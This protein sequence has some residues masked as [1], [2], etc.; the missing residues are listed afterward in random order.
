MIK[1]TQLEI[2]HEE[3][4]HKRENNNNNYVA[5]CRRQQPAAGQRRYP[6]PR[7]WTVLPPARA[8]PLGSCH[9]I[10]SYRSRKKR[11]KARHAWHLVA[12]PAW[13][14]LSQSSAIPIESQMLMSSRTLNH[15]HSRPATRAWR[16]PHF[17]KSF[18]LAKRHQPL[19]FR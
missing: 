9:A 11:L 6:V 8:S 4:H 3:A 19:R 15:L 14:A 16:R 13:S 2:L 1:D 18:P 12:E 17:I 10:A 5:P 7:R